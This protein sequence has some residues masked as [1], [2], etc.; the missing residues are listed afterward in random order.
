MPN[1][2][3]QQIIEEFRA[4]RGQV[5]GPFEGGRLLLLTTTGARTGA[6]HTT[7]VGYLPDGE[8]TL[9]IASAGGAQAHPAWYHNLLADPRVTVEDGVFTYPAEAVVL[10]GEERDRLFARAV[11]ADP[12]W[13][14]Y[15][16]R[17]ERVIP[18]IALNPL[19]GGPPAGPGGDS[20]KTIHDAFRRELALIRKELA[21]SGPGLGAQLRV[22]CLTLCQ[23]LHHHHTG[24]DGRM[25]PHL[26]EHH[27]ELA[28]ALARLRREH[29]V[30][31]RLLVQ[32]Q[33][34]ISGDGPGPG[35]VLA[36][37][38]RL[39]AELEAHLDYEEEQLVPILNAMTT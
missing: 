3:N 30:V 24:E 18:V 2:F 5:G 23:G 4:N 8:R 7:P 31:E 12:G 38:D 32:L 36:E 11:E 17:T 22:N 20:L 33:A 25:F 10:K 26:E 39:T 29:E 1:H 14:D 15:Q 35:A 16:A 37:V 9:I 19:G 13:A 27:P 21:E 6:R 34:L 28:P